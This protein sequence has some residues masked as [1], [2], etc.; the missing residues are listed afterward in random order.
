MTEAFPRKPAP[1]HTAPTFKE[2]EW[3]RRVWQTHVPSRA[4]DRLCL[5]DGCDAQWPCP[6]WRRAA[7]MLERSGL[8]DLDGRLRG[9]GFDAR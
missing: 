2:I 1:R 9:A 5:A 6:P 7:P 3:A 8:I 4:A